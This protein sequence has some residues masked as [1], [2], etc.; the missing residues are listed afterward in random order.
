[1]R[2]DEIVIDDSEDGDDVMAVEPNRRMDAQADA[3][4]ET[5]YDFVF[6]C[7]RFISFFFC[8]VCCFFR[9]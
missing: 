7:F 8:F 4:E 2:Q 3:E 6:V 9:P 5:Q 1:M